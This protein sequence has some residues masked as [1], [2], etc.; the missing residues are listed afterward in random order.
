ME[1]AYSRGNRGKVVDFTAYRRALE[2][3]A[4]EER[5][6]ERGKAR[7]RWL[8]ALDLMATGAILVMSVVVIMAFLPLL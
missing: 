1:M 2:A 7:A 8:T 4:A 3:P 6:K 5:P